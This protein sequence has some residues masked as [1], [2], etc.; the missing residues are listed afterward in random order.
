MDIEIVLNKN[1][2]DSY[3]IYLGDLD[4]LRFE[5]KVA[6]VTNK[7]IAPIHLAALR[8]KISAPE[9]SEI[10][11]DDGEEY[12][13][14]QT[15]E[16]ILDR[17]CDLRLDRRSV[18]IAFGGGVIGDM[19]GFCAAI[20]QRG[21]SFV[22]IPT[23]LLAMVD[24]SVGGK[25]GVNNSYG[26][27]LIGAF[28]QPLSV[29][30]DPAWLKTLPKREFLSGIAEIIKMAATLDKGFFEWLEKVDL[31]DDKTLKEAIVRSIR[32]KARIVMQ[33]EKESGA[34]A[35]LNY[36]HTFAHAIEKESGYGV[37]L[38]GESVAMGMVMANRLALSLGL[39]KDEEALRIKQAIKKF[40]LNPYYKTP[41]PE[42]FYE[43]FFLDKKTKN[44]NITFVLPRNIGDYIF[45]SD[46]PKKL[47][48][49]AIE[50]GGE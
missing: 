38:H 16:K 21:I 45:V 44:N 48:L 12:K 5:T 37:I 32:L 15:I 1:I 25:T 43:S 18:L 47:V 30:I 13:N 6:I 31:N 39:I 34:R 50:K 28:Y 26:K 33:D 20:Y 7:T 35:A 8:S 24:A 46:A 17:L 14:L 11:I 41:N 22:Q 42:L 10:I 27:N 29:H 4:P 40:G 2:D 36:G 19:T 3:K 49:E 23:T 9:I